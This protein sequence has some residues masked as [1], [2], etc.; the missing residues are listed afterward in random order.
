MKSVRLSEIT[1]SLSDYAR[2]GLREPVVVTR[3]GRPL[4]AVVPLT[5][6]DDWESVSL[7]TN[8]KFMEIIERSRASAREHGTLSLAEVRKRLVPK[9]ATSRRRKRRR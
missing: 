5:R 2:Q 6:F 7:S 1:G 8:A 4:V 9:R 3:Q